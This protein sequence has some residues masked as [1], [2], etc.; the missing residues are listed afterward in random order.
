MQRICLRGN[1]KD[2]WRWSKS[3]YSVKE[4]YSVIMDE[5]V[6]ESN[7]DKVL[8]K[9]WS[10]LVSLKFFALI[11]RIWQNKILIRDN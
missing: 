5:L 2:M 6:F 4:A 3:E 10:K 8:T 11:W 7:E 1:V 9:A